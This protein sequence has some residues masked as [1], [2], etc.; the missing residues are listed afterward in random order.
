MKIVYT[1]ATYYPETN[2]VQTVTQKQAEALVEC[3]YEVVVI[4]GNKKQQCEEEVYHGVK[5]LRIDAFNKIIFNCGDK[6]RFRELV[7][8]ECDNADFLITVCLLSFATNW[9]LDML[10]ELK[11]QKILYLHGIADFE[12]LQLRQLGIVQFVYRTIRKCYWKCYYAMH[13]NELKKFQAIIHIHEQDGSLDYVMQHGYI[14]NYIIYNAVEDALFETEQCRTDGNYFLYIANYCNG[15]NQ[16]ELLQYFYE[17]DLPCG[18]V[19]I[20]SEDNKYYKKLLK[21][22]NRLQK[23][24]TK[25]D[26]QI[27]HHV[28]RKRTIEYIQHAKAIV[29]TSKAEQFPISILEAMAARKPF[30]C[31]DVGVVSNLPGGIIYHNSKELVNALWKLYEDKEYCAILGT[32][33]NTYAMEHLTMKRHISDMEKV[34]LHIQENMNEG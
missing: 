23:V 14:N 29:M 22:K 31:S 2:G 24:Y 21:L 4:C 9:L 1:V 13:W 8:R 5:I 12:P 20:G 16:K 10:E 25:K 18:L 26:V 15:K 27:L 33:G 6:V 7:K 17:A 3:G 28:D 19:L 11:C 32:E 34:L 30:I